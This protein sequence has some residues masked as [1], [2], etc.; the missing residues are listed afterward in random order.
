MTELIEKAEKEAAMSPLM[1][2]MFS[3]ETHILNVEPPDVNGEAVMDRVITDAVNRGTEQ[4]FGGSRETVTQEVEDSP[5][6][7]KLKEMTK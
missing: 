6:V 3:A 4:L 5:S 2:P 7:R 1:W